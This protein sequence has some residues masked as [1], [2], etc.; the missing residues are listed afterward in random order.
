MKMLAYLLA[1][2][3]AIAAGAY[4][5]VPAG[6]L[7]TFMPGYAA[8][9]THIHTTHALAAAVAAVV[10]FGVGWFAGRR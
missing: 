8:G 1:I 10:L 5:F 7:P 2:I 4:Y 6:S 9:S 3:C